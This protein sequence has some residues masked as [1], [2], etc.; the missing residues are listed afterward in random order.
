MSIAKNNRAF[1]GG[2]YGIEFQHT[3]AGWIKEADGGHA[4]RDVVVEK[5]GSDHLHHKHLGPLKYEEIS[6]KC[7]T[8]MSA[9]IYDW[10]KTGFDQTSNNRGREDGAIIF[11]DYDENEITRLNWLQGLMTEFSMPALDASSKDAA[12]MTIKFQPEITR[13]IMG[14]GGKIKFP[15][16]ANIQKQ[17]LPSNFRLRIDG[18]DDPCKKVNKIEALTI[19]QKVTENAVGELIDYEKCPGSVEVPN[20]VITFSEDVAKPFYDW[21]E[22]FVIKGHNTEDKERGAHLEYLGS[23]ASTVLF[24][25]DFFHLGIF[26]V[27]PDKVEAGGE[28][29]RR[30]KAEMYCE[31]VKFNYNPAFIFGKR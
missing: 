6:F 31:D 20:L 7:G 1:T 25:M 24:T 28:A 8:G 30:V 23:D 21:H 5:I 9:G 3:L 19:K 29:V 11:A 18:L 17:W 16:S 4:S 15:Q 12:L 22:D 10:I 2:K 13:K 26:K 27:T 14:G